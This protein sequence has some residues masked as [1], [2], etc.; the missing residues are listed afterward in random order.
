MTSPTSLNETKVEM[1]PDTSRRM[2]LAAS[3]AFAVA[4]F[5]TPSARADITYTLQ[6]DPASSSQAQQVANSVA[7]AA[8]FYNQHGSFN[9]HWNV[10]YN[11]GIPT[12]E[13]NY[14]GY[15][16]FGGSRNERVVFHEAG[17]TFG[18]GQHSAY[19]TLVAGGVWKGQYGNQAQADTYNDYGDGLH[20]DNHAIWPGG[21][22]Y[23]NED[24]TIERFWHT[25]IMAG[26]RADMGILSYT[27]EAR[28]EAVVA[29]ETAEFQVVS[30]VAYAWQW[31]KN[32]VAL[33]NGGDISGA[34][35]ATLRIANAEAADAGA[36]RCAA[37][38]A[39]ETLNSRPRQLWV[40]AAPQIGQWN[41]NGNAN[42]SVNAYHGTAYG[43][44]AY[45]LGQAVDLDGTDDYIDLPD[46]VG[47]LRDLTI[48]TWVNWDGGANWQRVF[49]FGTGT[50]QNFFLTPKSG[51][52]TLR[53]VLKDSI[54]GKDVEY[55]ANASTLAIGQWVHLAAVL[56]G[57]YMTL[58]V[59]GRPTGSAFDLQSSPADFPATNNYIGKSQYPDPLFN[60][61]VDDFRIYAKALDGAEV[62]S[63]WGQSANHAPVF[64]PSLIVLPV[65]NARQP[66]TGQT[67]APFASDS[68]GNALTFTKLYGPGWLTV[69]AN[70]TLSGQ[71]G[72][73][74]GG[75]NTF[76][77]RVTDPSG[78][79][80]DATLQIEVFAPQV[81]VTASTTAPVTDSDDAYFF[82]SNIGEPD[83]INGTTTSTDNDESTYVAE[84]RTSKGQT[85]ATGSSPQ[86][87][88][89]QSF[90]FQ[91][92][93]WPSLTNP[94]TYYDIQPGDRWEF[95]IGTMNGTTKTALAKYTATYDGAALT[96]TGNSGTGRYLTFNVSGL[97]VQ[98]APSTTYYF[99][100]APLSGDPYFELNSSRNGTYAGG[101]AFRG[102]NAGTI[103]TGVNLLTGDY[104]FHVNLEA[105]SAT[106]SGTVAYWDFEEGTA[107]TY[108]PYNRTS[109]GQYEGS[110][111]DQ[112]GNANHLSVWG[113]GWHWYRANVPAAT[114]PQTGAANTLS[115]Q[116]A[117]SYPALSATG[118]S[119]SMWSPVAWTIEAAIRP[120]DATNGYQTFIGRDSYGAFAGNPALAALYFT[121]LPNGGLRFLFTDAAGNNWDLSSA[122]NTLQDAKWHAVA[123][124]SDG[125]TLSLYRKN[126]TDG[127]ASYTLLGTL[128]ISASA[129]PALS[130]GAGDGA[131]WDAGVFTVARGL[132][133]GGHTDRFFGHIDNVRLSQGVLPT[134]AFLY[135]TPLAA[136]AGL[137][138]TVTSSSQINLSWS[139]S[140]GATS[141]RVKR[142]ANAGGPYTLV[143]SPAGASYSHTG[144]SPATTHY[145]VVSAV[146]AGGESANG[147]EAGATT[148]SLLQAWR[149]QYFGTT[150]NTGA[151][152]DTFDANGDGEMNFMEFATAQ[153]PNAVTTATPVLV[154]NGANLEFTYTRSNAALADG[155]TFTVEWRDDLATAA[156]SSAGVTEQILNDNGTVQTVKAT[157]PAGTA[158]RFARLRVA[159]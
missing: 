40:H 23:D 25:R 54:N 29:G 86:G 133:N 73:G 38:G 77:V 91:H 47:R 64:S 44:P 70:G 123:A 1:N 39:G 95:E 55:Q 8:A 104:I 71:P 76:I 116:N 107:N 114:T 130:T 90:T 93:N 142:S 122:A 134:A 4:A 15:M 27:R 136:P 50:W 153:N 74:D 81:P 43:S 59:N 106:A 98:L 49:D 158:S 31:Y 105:R 66:Y 45:V 37:T 26:I 83:T 88:F 141:Y 53:L 42:D 115:L 69:A 87:Y 108:V 147:A 103:G 3:L 152:A 159:K 126:L 113:S 5:V 62:W 129:N 56:R 121:I 79:S 11:A 68:D 132:Y 156:W 28:N 58:Y 22:N 67:L 82:A 32:G 102:S 9:K 92:V 118:T 109:N 17:H 18:M 65:A 149:Q 51:G 119:L 21:F 154:R 34:T 63:L 24:G 157:L 48:A 94:G 72:F 125:D 84:D 6:F 144:L 19:F 14:S 150:A 16:G 131:D 36:Y 135:S 146:N 20:G 75:V 78:A 33:A 57:N 46:P 80:S 127:A 143:G 111:F 151:A 12:A 117:G 96:G 2:R 100:V 148:L 13:A 30:P 61:R 52:N 85:F 41:F 138:A 137:I 139:A 124:T 155:V 145:Y 10:Y 128:D 140:A 97:G 99:E 60:G 120:D 101:T 110:I 89:L 112:S 7:V 35:T